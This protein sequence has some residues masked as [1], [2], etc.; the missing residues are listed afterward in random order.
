MSNLN[1]QQQPSTSSGSSNN[2]SSNNQNASSQNADI[3]KNA[4]FN[5][6]KCQQHSLI[7]NKPVYY[8][9]CLHILC[10]ECFDRL[11]SSQNNNHS[12]CCPACRRDTLR[13]CIFDDF[14]YDKNRK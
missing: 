14:T 2:G 12:I 4:R 6:S 10:N 7:P 8:L 9:P 3:T 1:N 5:C 11:K 13:E